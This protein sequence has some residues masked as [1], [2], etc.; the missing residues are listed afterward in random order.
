MDASIPSTTIEGGPML[1]S[2][3]G[4]RMLLVLVLFLATLLG[5]STPAHAQG[6]IKIG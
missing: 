2:T 6:P 4:P 1:R 3:H 5:A